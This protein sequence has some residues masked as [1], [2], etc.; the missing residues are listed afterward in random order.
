MDAMT[1]EPLQIAE[2][3]ISPRVE[4][5]VKIRYSEI[6]ELFFGNL[7]KSGVFLETAH[8]F[9]AVGEKLQLEM[10]L[11]GA[12]D[13]VKVT[14]KVIRIVGPHKVGPAPGMGIEFLRIETRQVKTFERM[15]DRLL[16]ARGIGSRKHPRLNMQL[17]VKLSSR[18]DIRDA[19]SENLSRGGIFV[20]TPI[21]GYVLGDSVRVLLVH[22]A[23][24]RKFEVDAKVVHLRKGESR[25][26]S[27]FIEGLGIQ[28]INLSASRRTDMS[29]FLRSILAGKR[30]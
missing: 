2:R 6:S 24:K 16:D 19:I 10:T 8:P 26:R 12:E 20:K 28:F 23:S 27:D 13:A 29:D 25:I 18:A 7:S 17:V 30:R 11:P 21:N 3:R 1:A 5:R 22:P 9:A 14:G 15:I 4:T